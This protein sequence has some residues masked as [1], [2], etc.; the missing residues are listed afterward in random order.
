MRG[1]AAMVVYRGEACAC[2]QLMQGAKALFFPS[3]RSF[4]SRCFPIF[5]ISC[6]QSRT[7]TQLMQDSK[8]LSLPL[9]SGFVRWEE[10]S[11][12]NAALGESRTQLVQSAKAVCM[13]VF[14]GTKSRW[15][16]FP[17]ASIDEGLSQAQLAQHAQAALL[18]VGS[19]SRS[20]RIVIA[21]R[22]FVFRERNAGAELLQ[23]R[24][25]AL[26][27]SVFSGPEREPKPTFI[28]LLVPGV[29]DTR[30][31]KLKRHGLQSPRKPSDQVGLC[32]SPE[33]LEAL[34]EAL[35]QIRDHSLAA[36][37]H[38]ACDAQR[39]AVLAGKFGRCCVVGLDQL[40]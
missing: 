4:V 11:S 25:Q 33:S 26:G 39:S 16:G 13:S 34:S 1:R 22:V 28:E 23:N 9:F 30:Y 7:C 24:S 32:P 14:S 29:V 3:Y 20:S 35:L 36:R 5:F 6:G 19:G 12:S 21:A 40:R 38:Y 2:A 17:R 18:S 8:A 31:A 10:P 37:V 27:V 15:E